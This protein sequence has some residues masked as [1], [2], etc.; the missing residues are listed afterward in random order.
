MSNGIQYEIK[1]NEYYGQKGLILVCPPSFCL[2]CT[3]PLVTVA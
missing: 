2:R 3:D 1:V